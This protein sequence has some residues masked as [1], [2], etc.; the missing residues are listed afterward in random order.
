[1]NTDAQ[2]VTIDLAL[3]QL[4]K[5]ENSAN[6]DTTL[7]DKATRALDKLAARID[8]LEGETDRLRTRL[9]I[10]ADLMRNRLEVGARQAKGIGDDT[11]RT[12]SNHDGTLAT[13]VADAW[14]FIDSADPVCVTM[15]DT[16]ERSGWI[17]VSEQ[18]RVWEIDAPYT[19]VW[20]AWELACAVAQ[21]VEA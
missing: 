21:A 20:D 16:L 4:A 2:I 14:G 6:G 8:E 19:A 10:N 3:C 15:T 9:Q 18:G 1:M 17:G 13:Y 12:V 5:I 7:A 11:T